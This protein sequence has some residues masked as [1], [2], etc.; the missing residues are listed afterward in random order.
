[1]TTPDTASTRSA[2]VPPSQFV[3]YLFLSID[4]Q[5]RLV[6]D[7]VRR[8]GRE[9]FAAVIRDAA[10]EVTT[11]AY[12]T[13]GLKVGAE[14]MLW[15]K[16]DTPEQMQQTLSALFRTGLGRHCDIA[17]SLWGYSRPSIY[18]KRHTTQ[19]Q[20]L[21]AEARLRYLVVYP[22]VKTMDWYLM[23]REARQ[24]M[25]NEHIRVGHEFDDVRQVL[26]YATGLDD[27]EFIVAYE[28]ETLER[29]QDLVMA[30]RATEARRYTLRD[31]PIFT[32]V[33]RSLQDALALV[34]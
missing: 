24:G 29:H 31:T 20:A 13:L 2:S 5:W 4:R 8:R 30:L 33:H 11:F 9:E 7:D 21:G 16:T 19:E 14:L 17:Y 26:L 15:W 6:E 22:F 10:P 32:A 34:G 1:M 3:Q 12:T 18:T 27:Q 23:S 28:T 25:M